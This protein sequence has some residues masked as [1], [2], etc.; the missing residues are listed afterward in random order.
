MTEPLGLGTPLAELYP[1]LTGR[2]FVNGPFERL[3][4]GLL[5]RFIHHGIRPEIGLEGNCLYDRPLAEFQEVAQ[6]LQR[7]GL[8]CTLHAPFGD[9]S[10]GASDPEIRRASRNKLRKALALIE[11]FAPTAIVC[12]LGYEAN[13]HAWKQAEWLAHSLETWQALLAAA[14]PSGVPLMLENTYEKSPAIHREIFTRLDSP[15]ARFCLDVGHTL[16][17]AGNSWRDWLP[18]LSPWLGHLHLHDNRGGRDEHLAVGQ[19][20]FDFAGL[21]AYLRENNLCPTI[22]LEPHREADLVESLAALDKMLL[23]E[24]P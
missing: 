18:E 19:G 2:L 7:A 3:R 5:A 21:F 15:G 17:F 16:A 10:P 22:T 13:K 6:A 9:L 4:Q 11:I 23:P 1:Q 12:H 24:P 8:A 14:A 20:I